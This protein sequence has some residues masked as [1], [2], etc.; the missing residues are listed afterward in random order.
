MRIVYGAEAARSAI[1]KRRPASEAELGAEGRSTTAAVFGGEISVV[2]SVRR[3]ISD[4]RN[5]GDAAVRRYC[6]AFE[7]VT[8]PSFEIPREQIEAAVREIEPELRE[9]LEFAA[10]RVRRYHE[11]QMRRVL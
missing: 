3:I 7:G 1:L 6:E 2:E 11:G 10:T 9:A 4:V 8:Y 5:E